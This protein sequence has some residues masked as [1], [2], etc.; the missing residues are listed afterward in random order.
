M[1]YF[2]RKMDSIDRGGKVAADIFCVFILGTMA[3]GCLGVLPGVGATV[4]VTVGLLAIDY[5]VPDAD[6]SA[7]GAIR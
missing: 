7:A 3:A 6:D 1:A 2:S 5:F 4:L